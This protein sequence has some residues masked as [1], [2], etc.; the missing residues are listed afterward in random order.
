[1]TPTPYPDSTAHL[2]DEL[3]RLD[4]M[5][6]LH[7]EE[8]WADGGGEFTGLYISDE[9][10]DRLLDLSGRIG[11]D[12]TALRE[13]G[14]PRTDRTETL[15][16]HLE[17]IT[18]EIRQREQATAGTDTDLRLLELAS[19]FDLAASHREALLFALAPE[20]ERKYEKVY[21]Y[22][23]D[24][25]TRTRPT[26]EL[27][28]RMLCSTTVERMEAREAFTRRSPLVRG[29]L[30][31]LL[32]EDTAPLP[33]RTVAVDDRV[34]EYLL[35]MDD[36]PA[37]LAGVVSVV[38]PDQGLETLAL[39]ETVRDGLTAQAASSEDQS[40]LVY[41]HGPPGSG[42]NDAVEAICAERGLAVVRADADALGL[43][44]GHAE[45][46]GSTAGGSPLEALVREARLQDGAIHLRRLAAPRAGKG[47][48]G[49]PPEL[50]DVVTG[51][52]EGLAPYDG[53]VFLSGDRA[54]S[55]RVGA[56]LDGW[57]VRTVAFDTPGYDRRVELWEAVE[58]LPEGVEPA[59]LASKFAL[60]A[61]QVE[62]AVATART[63]TGGRE[64][65]TQ[66][67]YAACRSQ[68]RERLGALARAVETGYTWSDIVLP[69]E[70][71]THLQEVA[72]HVKHQGK[73]YSEWGFSGKYSTGNGLNVLFTGPSGTGK[74]MAAE[75][76]AGEA[77]LDLYRLDLA[78]VVSK[79]IGETEENLKAVFDEAEGSNAVLFFDEA[80]ALFGER[81]DV[82][83]S[84]D[85]YA[86]VE[87]SYLL[88]RMENH[89]GT[90]IL[91]SNLKENIDDAFLRR[92]NLSVEFPMPDR[93]ARK[94]IWRSV[95]PAATPTGELDVDFLAEFDLA[96]GSIKNAALTAAFLAAEDD[97]P[98][99]M[100]HLVQA[101][102]RE[103][104]KTG[105]LIDAEDFGEYGEVLKR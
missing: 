26:V 50:E 89:D 99:G 83:D 11:D 22:L 94:Q 38:H 45:R 70:T 21:A 59:G 92:I 105:R 84:Q 73:I 1:M 82:S 17:A 104:E 101:L 34:V 27:L 75:I 79:Y 74:T 76:V 20:L 39:G 96:G 52:V 35:G 13:T 81:S 51:I 36:V 61:G 56:R 87:V 41:T 103:L 4:V 97:E 12:G 6:R 90:V 23:Q 14:P 60:T 24:D 77:G 80:D 58:D 67:V 5:L 28:L 25:V 68:S 7:L 9:E 72:A 66:A 8:W 78:S 31:R 69:E 85:R 2:R 65:S 46:R 95:F 29:G 102:R 98:V 53:P 91:A 63:I 100:T 47:G 93:D 43:T 19:R 42:E 64:L 88:Q 62:D 44:D 57:S 48:D 10:V 32:G 40:R 15:R 71:M 33:S 54:L 30:I 18:E 16:A 86:N 49:S 55:P 3:R 37:P